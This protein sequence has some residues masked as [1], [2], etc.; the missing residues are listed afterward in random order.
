MTTSDDQ[1]VHDN[2]FKSP[3]CFLNFN[4]DRLEFE[5]KVNRQE[6]DD[7]TIHK[8][9]ISYEKFHK[10]WTV[11]RIH[12]ELPILCD[13]LNEDLKCATLRIHGG[14]KDIL[15]N[16]FSSHKKEFKLKIEYTKNEKNFEADFIV[17]IPN[18][19]PQKSVNV[20]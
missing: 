11:E 7:V 17:L 9:V 14:F 19:D 16:L 10:S 8:K 3:A 15:L 20:S 12:R 5:L 1:E 2:T 13:E 6:W 18:I 4:G